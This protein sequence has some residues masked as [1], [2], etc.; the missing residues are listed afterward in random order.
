MSAPR[1]P[2]QYHG[3]GC[4]RSAGHECAHY[5]ADRM[6]GWVSDRETARGPWT[7]CNV[8]HPTARARCFCVAG[9]KGSH[10]ALL[11]ALPAGEPTSIKGSPFVEW[12]AKRQ[13]KDGAS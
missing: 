8:E 9:H 3:H 13:P 4:G 7:L 2:S 1:C 10:Y 11:G 6:A 5:S 12:R